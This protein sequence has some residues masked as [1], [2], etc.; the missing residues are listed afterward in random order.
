MKLIKALALIFLATQL[1]FADINFNTNAALGTND[2][3]SG[4]KVAVAIAVSAGVFYLIYWLVEG[5]DNAL[6]NKGEIRYTDRTE[7]VK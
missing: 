2:S 6:D 3:N 5:R 7:V 1:S 4:P